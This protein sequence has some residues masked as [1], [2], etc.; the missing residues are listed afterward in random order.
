MPSLTIYV[1]KHIYA[2]L[3]AECER[4]QM[5][6]SEFINKV[7]EVYFSAKKEKDLQTSPRQ[8]FD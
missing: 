4:L 1:R 7:L 2:K 3:I 8:L 6:E 5:G